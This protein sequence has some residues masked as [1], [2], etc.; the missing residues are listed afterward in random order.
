MARTNPS[1]ANGHGANP[2]ATKT[3]KDM[4]CR[5]NQLDFL[6][7]VLSDATTVIGA[8]SGITEVANKQLGIIGEHGHQITLAYQEAKRR[9]K[10]YSIIHRN[11]SPAYD[12]LVAASDTFK[13]VARPYKKRMREHDQKQRRSPTDET[14]LSQPHP[15]GSQQSPSKTTHSHT[16][17]DP[18]RATRAAKPDPEPQPPTDTL[19]YLTEKK[20]TE[21]GLPYFNKEIIPQIQ[22]TGCLDFYLVRL[23]GGSIELFQGFNHPDE[24]RDFATTHLPTTQQDQYIFRKEQTPEGIDYN[25]ITLEQLAEQSVTQQDD[26]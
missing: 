8:A 6:I 25:S 2:R 12:R 7:D 23:E 26:S 13:E 16:L 1:R 10:G 5:L 15:L 22:E 4:K 19:D 24:I 9:H 18:R 17:K 11:L 21:E 20:L 14:L 3:Y